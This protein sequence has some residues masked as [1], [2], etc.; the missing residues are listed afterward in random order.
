MHSQEPRVFALLLAWCC[1]ECRKGCLHPER[2]GA[3]CVHGQVTS[4]SL[5]CLWVDFVFFMTWIVCELSAYVKRK[6][7]LWLN[8]KSRE[9]YRERYCSGTPVSTNGW[10]CG[11]LMQQSQA[12][13]CA[14]NWTKR[15]Y[16]QTDLLWHQSLWGRVRGQYCFSA[17]G[18]DLQMLRWSSNV[19]W[20]SDLSIWAHPLPRATGQ[21]GC[22]PFY[23]LY[24]PSLN[25]DDTTHVLHLTSLA[26]RCPWNPTFSKLWCDS[27][28]QV[29]RLSMHQNGASSASLEHL[30]PLWRLAFSIDT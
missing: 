26:M 16:T 18:L 14:Q 15:Q 21:Q 12:F 11:W 8:R 5:V 29:K 4:S 2:P 19:Y 22:K 23:A 10:G 17:W 27:C 1:H 30:V 28:Q 25:W 20:R 3:L 7:N 6:V 13:L 24:C 9:G